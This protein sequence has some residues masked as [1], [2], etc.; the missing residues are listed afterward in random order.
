MPEANTLSMALGSCCA[1]PLQVAGAYAALAA[2]GTATEPFLISLVKDEAG[3]TLYKHRRISRC[4][5]SRCAPPLLPM[6]PCSASR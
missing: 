2:R 1:S 5:A 4:A 6:D 3:S